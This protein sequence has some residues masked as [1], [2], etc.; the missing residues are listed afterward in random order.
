ML[1]HIFYGATGK[2]RSIVD[3]AKRLATF[4]VRYDIPNV[5]VSYCH[6]DDV[7]IRRRIET[8]IIPL[9]AF[10]EG[11]LRI[12]LGKLMTYF[13][14]HFKLCPDQSTLD[15]FR[16]VSSV[17]EQNKRLSLNLSEHDIN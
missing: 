4:R 11:G 3:I 12:P 2:F 6:E 7:N 17:A 13:L 8:M 1:S 9:V 10:K 16:V 14:R 5:G 15:I